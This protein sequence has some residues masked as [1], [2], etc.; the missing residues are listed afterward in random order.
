VTLQLLDALAFDLDGGREEP[1]YRTLHAR[2]VTEISSGGIR[3]GTRL[4]STRS[5]ARTLGVSRATVI[6]AFEELVSEGY[7]Q[8]QLGSGT[9]VADRLP[10]G[11]PP[12]PARHAARSVPPSRPDRPRGAGSFSGVPERLYVPRRP[13]PFRPNFPSLDDFPIDLWARLT[14]RIYRRHSSTKNLLL[15]EGDAQGYL[16][17]RTAIA[18]HVRLS[19]G[20]RCT[21]DNVIIFAGA[22]QALDVTSRLLLA[23][24]DHAWCEDPGYEGAYAAIIASG[25]V[26]VPVP[27]DGEGMSVDEGRRRCEGARL[28]FVCPSKQ[29]PL[30]MEMT[31]RRRLQLLEWAVAKGAWIIEDDYDNEFRFAGRPVPALHAI[32][33]GERVIYLGTFSKVLFPALRLGFA[34]IPDGLVDAFV[35][36]RGVVGRYSP[37]LEQMV[38]ADFMR[39]GHFASHL[40]RMRKLYSERHE[41]MLDCARRYLPDFIKPVPSE[42]GMQMIATVADEFDPDE[43]AGTAAAEGLEITPVSWFAVENHTPAALILGFSAFSPATIEYG[44]KRLRSCFE[45]QHRHSALR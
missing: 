16:P 35:A 1:L 13:V 36:A 44:M 24:G 42:T 34:V 8:G 12:A 25:A 15:G 43:V 2:L 20:V 17:L 38:V 33:E 22:Q 40:L 32:D 6:L 3:P 45:V 31:L 21:G 5:L 11:P 29:F 39:E 27:V 10:S 30:G 7:L 9:Y 37:L 14:A 23:P 28:A 41:V 19:R 18:E 26:P 4:P